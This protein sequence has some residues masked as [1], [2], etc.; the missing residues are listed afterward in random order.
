M[1]E[2]EPENKPAPSNSKKDE[3]PEVII[4]RNW[5]EYLGE[6][7]LIVF[8]VALAIILTEVFTKIHEN[9]QTREVLHQ[10]KLEL[11]NN[12]EA[13]EVQY[14]YHLM[15]IHN[16][17]SALHDAKLR[18]AFSD[19]GLIHLTPIAPLGVMRED[20]ND[21]AW[22]VAKQNNIF[23]KLSLETYR[24][25]TDIYDNQA[26]IIKSEDEIGK[27]LLSFES[28]E[29]GNAN[30]TLILMRDIYK[31]WAVDRAPRLLNNYKKAINALS[32]Y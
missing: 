11:I 19:S 17:D 16:I 21:I 15:V 28:R 20:L 4:V 8:S 7:L 31:A 27:L 26:K 6:S 32:D 23:S 2:V 18:K 12:N 10:L 24:L 29:S 5:K 22:Q 1:E 13:E 9:Q 3:R 25:L 14:R 30:T